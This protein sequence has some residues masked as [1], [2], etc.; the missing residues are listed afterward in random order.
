MFIK[1]SIISELNNIDNIVFGNKQR[2]D[3]KIDFFNAYFTQKT[4]S[5]FF[6]NVQKD[7]F[8]NWKKS[9]FS[10][11]GWN[12]LRGVLVLHSREFWE[13]FCLVLN[14]LIKYDRMKCVCLDFIDTIFNN[15]SAY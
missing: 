3:V 14:D 8:I 9:R 7:L 1:I 10:S 6:I 4:F 15:V 5:S 13:I 11:K 2:V 12:F